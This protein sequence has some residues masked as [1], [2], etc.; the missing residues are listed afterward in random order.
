MPVHVALAL[1]VIDINALG[2]GHDLG[3]FLLEGRE[4]RP[5]MDVVVPVLLP[6]VVVVVLLKVRPHRTLLL[7]H[8]A[9]GA[10]GRSLSRR[11]RDGQRKRRSAMLYIDARQGYDPIASTEEHP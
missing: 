9:S 8:A 11:G 4:V 7:R 5:W 6:K 1:G 2:L 3:A 10:L